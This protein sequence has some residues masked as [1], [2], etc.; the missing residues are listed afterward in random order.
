MKGLLALSRGI[1]RLNETIGKLVSWLILLAILVGAAG[2]VTN[3]TSGNEMTFPTTPSGAVCW[4]WKIE[5]GRV[6]APATRL[7]SAMPPR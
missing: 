3:P 2:M 7:V 6:A 1:D 5:N 4:K